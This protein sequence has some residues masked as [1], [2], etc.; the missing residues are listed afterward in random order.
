MG[1]GE[2]P[3]RTMDLRILMGAC[4]GSS[5][6]LTQLIVIPA[7]LFFRGYIASDYLITGLICSVLVS[8]VIIAVICYFV[9]HLRNAERVLLASRDKAET[10]NRAKSMFLAN[11][12]H[13]LRTPLNAIL[14]FSEMIE[15]GNRAD[16]HTKYAGYIHESGRHLLAIIND[17][18]DLS[19]VDAGK[20]KMYESE[21]DLAE[22][23]N[24]C[25]RL[26]RS[27]AG[28]A[29]IELAVKL[30]GELPRLYADKRL[31]KQILLNL[32]SNSIKFTPE[33]GRVTLSCC[34]GGDG[35]VCFSVVDTGAG[36]EPDDIDKAFAP[37]VQLENGTARKHG[38]A[39]LGLSLVKSFVE[40]HGGSVK[41][42]SAVGKG[43]SVTLH[44][45]PGRSRSEQPL[46]PTRSDLSKLEPLPL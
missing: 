14:G 4:I 11:M 46:T 41:A 1:F 25:L 12:S 29:G 44:F 42:T 21:V 23:A 15:T 18:L 20:L 6:V 31:L 9:R 7:S 17:L 26:V 43:M 19:R 2:N 37:F 40:L 8:A 30:D 28:Q 22:V 38:G 5:L 3:L 33:S 39:G 36:M 13:E 34:L 10:A 45:P 32:L 35:G 27:R 16:D 24:S